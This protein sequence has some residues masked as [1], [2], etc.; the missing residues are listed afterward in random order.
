MEPLSVSLSM[1]SLD[2]NV[3]VSLGIILFSS[4]LQCADFNPATSSLVLLHIFVLFVNT[5]M[6]DSSCSTSLD[7]SVVLSSRRPAVTASETLAVVCPDG[8][9]S[10]YFGLCFTDSPKL[11]TVNPEGK[12]QK[13]EETQ[14]R[15]GAKL[16][17]RSEVIG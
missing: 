11:R 15:R 3:H 8:P 6:S 1:S 14:N 17:R 13:L 9:D 5:N 16:H 2:S 12:I 7:L 10:L 4:F